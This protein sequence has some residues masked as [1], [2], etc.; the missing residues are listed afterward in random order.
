VGRGSGARAARRGQPATAGRA[1]GPGLALAAVGI[2][3]VLGLTLT[4]DSGPDTGTFRWCVLCG[5][6]GAADFIANVALFVPLAAGLV[7]AGMRGRTIVAAAFVLSAL[8]ETLQLWIPGRESTLGDIISNTSGAALVVLAWHFWA[9]R[10]SLAGGALAAAAMLVALA[11]AGLA[12]RPSLPASAWYGQW[13]AALAQ[14][15]TYGG[16]VLR[17]DLDGAPLPDG[18]LP[19]ARSVRDSLAGGATLRVLA[20]AGPRTRTL[21]PLFGIADGVQREILELG[22]DRDDLV[23]RVRRRAADLGLDAPDLR[24]R[25]ALAG[26]QPGDT[27]ALLA[28]RAGGGWCLAVNGRE[29]CGLAFAAGRAWAL[30]HA[31]SGLPAAAQAALDC[32]FMALLA[33]PVGALLKR[34]AAGAAVALLAL[35]GAAVLPVLVGLSPTPAIQLAASYAGLAAGALTPGGDERADAPVDAG[36]R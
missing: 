24:W 21:A 32:A 13:T 3:V 34:N 15:E 27:L 18:P 33:L 11:G 28:R 23:L 8:I 9:R 31:M 17:V 4:P 10:R 6:G 14:F 1:R 26:V 36:V 22:A 25:G 30:V 16:R 12:L 7:L 2:A 29:R 35:G 19:D 20:V 5:D